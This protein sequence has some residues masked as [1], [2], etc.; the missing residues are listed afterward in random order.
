MGPALRFTPV[1][2]V[3]DLT[4]AVA[5]WSQALGVDPAFVDGD[6]WAQFDTGDGR[7]LALSGTDRVAD[8]PALMAKVDDLDQAS[9]QLE[10]A[11]GEVGPVEQGAHERRCTVLT[12][13][14]WTLVLYSPSPP[15]A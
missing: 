8:E 10:A 12:P 6:R 5:F 1:L 14:G 11:G 4:F 15:A 9:A 3:P 7:R 2:P 13:G